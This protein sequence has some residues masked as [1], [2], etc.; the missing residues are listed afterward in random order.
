MLGCVYP[1][2]FG[3][4]VDSAGGSAGDVSGY[5]RTPVH[6]RHKGVGTRNEWNLMRPVALRPDGILH[7]RTYTIP[8]HHLPPAKVE[9]LALARR[10]ASLASTPALACKEKV[11]P[12]VATPWTSRLNLAATSLPT[13]RVESIRS[14]NGPAGNGHVVRCFVPSGT[15]ALCSWE[16][17]RPHFGRRELFEKC[18]SLGGAVMSA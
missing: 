10:C 9:R 11:V 1:R 14:K 4:D 6:R 18:R 7:P 5:S 8:H 3:V 2:V 15:R 16:F 17:P 13:R 12:T